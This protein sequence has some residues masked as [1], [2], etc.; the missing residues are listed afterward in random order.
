MLT[1]FSQDFIYAFRQFRRNLGFTATVVLTLA[2]C[3]GATTAVFSLVDGILLH[4]LPFPQPERLVA[5]DTLEFPS[6]N[7]TTD[8]LAANEVATSYPDYFDWRQ[9]NH[10]F[11]WLA[12]CDETSRLFS[13][14]NG[15][16][17]RV[18]RGARVSGNLFSTLG[19]APMLGR[20]F[21]GDDELPGH[22]VIM[23]SHELWVSDFAASPTAL[24]QTVKISDQPYVV[25]GVMPK[26]FHFP[27]AE[28]GLFW[29]TFAIDAEGKNPNTLQ[30]NSDRVKIIGPLRPDV[31]RSEALADLNTIQRQLAQQYPE[32]RDWRGVALV[33]LLEENVG[34]SKS[35]LYLLMAAVMALLLIG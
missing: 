27:I 4:P 22:R 21:F 5:I 28:P 32:I 34:G 29:T 10:T 9:Q 19:V 11:E 12:S 7:P 3:I 6:G 35:S 33:P 18:I 17:A 1:K 25:V 26:G 14:Q 23:L 16:G 13:K 24:G 31:Q 15:E 8:P 30:R 2:I 20:D